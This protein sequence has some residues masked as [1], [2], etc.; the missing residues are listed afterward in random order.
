MADRGWTLAVRRL[1]ERLK[2]ELVS[3]DL[4]SSELSG[5]LSQRG[6]PFS[7]VRAVMEPS[8][9]LPAEE[10]GQAG[11]GSFSQRESLAP[12]NVDGS[13][14][15]DFWS[16]EQ[17]V[18]K[19]TV[20]AVCAAVAAYWADGRRTSEM[21]HLVSAG[22]PGTREAA[23]K[24]VDR[25]LGE[26]GGAA[27]MFADLDGLKALNAK[28]GQN[29]VD[30]VLEELAGVLA[31]A[32][33]A[34]VLLLHR[35]GDEF[36]MICPGEADSALGT[37][38]AV[39]RA[40]VDHKFSI[41][42]P[43]DMSIGVCAVHP[44][45]TATTFKELEDRAERA[46]KPE[47]ADGTAPDKVRRGRAS[48][49][50]EMDEVA[51]L[52]LSGEGERSLAG[53]LVKSSVDEPRP[54][55]NPW[56]NFI[57]RESYRAL[58]DHGL[59][60]RCGEQISA[61]ID[62]MEPE[63]REGAAGAAGVE[64]GASPGPR[65]SPEDVAYAIGHGALRA[66]FSGELDA[67]EATSVSVSVAAS[68]ASVAIAPGLERMEV[69][70]LVGPEVTVDLGGPVFR[71]GSGPVDPRRALLVK[72]GHASIGSVA[73]LFADIVTV[74]DRPAFGG[75]LPDFWEASIARV[76]DSLERFP[77][78]EL[79]A[80]LGDVT[81]GARTVSKLQESS[82][83]S[84]EAESLAFR[85]GLS[86]TVLRR[87]ADRLEGRVQAFGSVE[88]VVAGVAAV[89]RDRTALHPLH[90]EDP[91]E[92]ERFLRLRLDEGE[93]ELPPESGCRVDTGAQ[94]Y[95]VV[96]ERLRR[97]GERAAIP[98][99]A[100]VPMIDLIDFKIQVSEPDRDQIPSFYRNDG[101]ALEDYYQTAFLDEEDGKF[102]KELREQVPRV[103][104]HVVA[105]IRRRPQPFSTRRAILVVPHVLV[106]VDEDVAFADLS[107]LGL[108]SV[109]AIP[110]FE[111]G[112]VILQFSF[113]WRTV[114]ALVG[115]PY[116]LFGSLR[117][118]Q[119]LTEK[120]RD[121]LEEA[122]AGIPIRL[123]DVSYIAHS[124]HVTTEPY[125]LN[126][127]RRIIQLAGE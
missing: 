105:A 77:D 71:E 65:L 58:V 52:E 76:V 102:A 90:E 112:H 6:S 85:T 39:K 69:V 111:G 96:L 116:S 51:D 122:E 93:F 8:G 18:D 14:K 113:T 78:L 94:A 68:G 41:D 32:C 75:A 11:P 81:L 91:V 15:V 92:E 87:A 43:V 34:D 99:A 73:G 86:E 54:L 4:F 27:V 16:T 40:I 100:G 70:S 114:E 59:S 23:A 3:R 97:I 22:S 24:A 31:S 45:E 117:Y 48:L 38:W 30:T 61:A 88:E 53:A 2:H 63:T 9:A 55:V 125:G 83:W 10:L 36:L 42:D 74:D 98:D 101:E 115:L 80:I 107:P 67:P 25:M 7:H 119:H 20:G 17:P 29:Q 95:P 57:S 26:I 56:L 104:A 127:A 109:R 44:W 1:A 5:L 28:H 123:G 72:I 12:A 66:L 118:S 37:A 103:V 89:L 49:V 19:D 84:D 124:L 126:V 21:T 110:R 50:P 120:V 62:W 64:A 60:G 82:S 108:V 13:F 121:G 79:V 35:S 33:P 106:P 46:M 47:P